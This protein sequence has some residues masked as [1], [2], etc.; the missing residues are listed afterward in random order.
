M[1]GA[2]LEGEFL[3]E[4]PCYWLPPFKAPLKCHLLPKALLDPSLASWIRRRSW[5]AWLHPPATGPGLAGGSGSRAGCSSLVLTVAE[6]QKTPGWGGVSTPKGGL[7]GPG[8]TLAGS[9]C[10]EP[11]EH[12]RF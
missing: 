3:A 8:D 6:C 11:D 5:G 1:G 10:P 4:E 12:G 7:R 9:C 2:W